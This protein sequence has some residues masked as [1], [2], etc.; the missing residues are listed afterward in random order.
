VW[1]QGYQDFKDGMYGGLGG[2]PRDE[3]VMA[4]L[5]DPRIVGMRASWKFG[6]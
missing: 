3:S 1:G 5:P 6:N 4:F 2:Q